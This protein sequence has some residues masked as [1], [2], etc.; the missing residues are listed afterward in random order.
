MYVGAINRVCKLTGN[1]T[2]QVAHK[3]GPEEDSKSCYPPLIV[4]PCGEVLTR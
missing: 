1:L 2:I 4:Q 3:T